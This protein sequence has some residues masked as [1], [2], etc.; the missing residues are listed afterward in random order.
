MEAGGAPLFVGSPV[1]P[2]ERGFYYFGAGVGG[3]GATT[4]G[5]QTRGVHCGRR[6]TF[7]SAVPRPPGD[8]RGSAVAAGAS[9]GPEFG[10]AGGLMSRSVSVEELDGFNLGT[11]H[12]GTTPSHLLLG[13][14][15]RVLFRSSFLPLQGTFGEGGIRCF[16]GS[17]PPCW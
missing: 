10:G 16:L 7:I 1:L 11:G 6:V 17:R 13:E 8:G 3:G 12:F 14:R 5:K 4:E 2:F 9:G 15:S